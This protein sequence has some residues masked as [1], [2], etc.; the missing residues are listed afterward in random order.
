MYC[1]ME[2]DPEIGRSCFEVV[3]HRTSDCVNPNTMNSIGHLAICGNA[4]KQRI[5]NRVV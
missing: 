1:G 5:L 4:A 3:L 2:F